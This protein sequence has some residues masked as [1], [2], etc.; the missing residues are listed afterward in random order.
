LDWLPG[1][2]FEESY[3]IYNAVYAVAHTIHEMLL[4]QIQMQIV[5][6]A[7]WMVP[8]LSQAMAFS[9]D[10]TGHQNVSL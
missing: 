6:K 4:H 9:L 5:G 7:N 3:N 10:G 1:N 2:L 8:S